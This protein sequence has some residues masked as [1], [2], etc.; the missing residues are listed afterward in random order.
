M[1]Y[2]T[3]FDLLHGSNKEADPGFFM[4][5]DIVLVSIQYRVGVFGFLNANTPNI[6][7]NGAIHD[8]LTALRWIRKYISL[9]GGNPNSVT[10][11][12][13]YKVAGII[14]LLTMIPEAVM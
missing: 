12:G 11:F 14:Q 7:G 6:P 3:G 9:F 1:V 13:Q 2:I 5:R 10:L 8:I 4:E